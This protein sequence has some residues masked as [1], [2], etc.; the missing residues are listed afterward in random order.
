MTA[1]IGDVNRH[2][3]KLIAKTD[4]KGNHRFAKLWN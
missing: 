3:Q 1:Q 2:G 4:E